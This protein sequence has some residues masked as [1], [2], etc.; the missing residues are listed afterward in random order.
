MARFPDKLPLIQCRPARNA[1]NTKV[2]GRPEQREVIFGWR[3]SGNHVLSMT[4]FADRSL[5]VSEMLST[6][7]GRGRTYFSMKHHSK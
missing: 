1:L 7:S 3:L 5:F 2:L 6:R 4:I